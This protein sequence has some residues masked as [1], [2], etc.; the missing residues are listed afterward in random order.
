LKKDA[1]D[2]GV[3]FGGKILAVKTTLGIKSEFFE[4]VRRS[5]K[6]SLQSLTVMRMEQRGL[7]EKSSD[8]F[9]EALKAQLR[10]AG[11]PVIMR[12]IGNIQT[13][14]FCHQTLILKIA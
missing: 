9:D 2:R 4:F 5:E 1:T 14:Q 13:G 8:P 11:R 10:Q 3:Q 12:G 6:I 7:Q